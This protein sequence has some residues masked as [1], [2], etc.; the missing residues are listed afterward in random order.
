MAVLALQ[1]GAREV[2]LVSWEQVEG[3]V[4]LPGV[5]GASRQSRAMF[6]QNGRGRRISMREQRWTD[7][8][9]GFGV[10]WER[11]EEA[12]LEWCD[13]ILDKARCSEGYD[14]GF[15]GVR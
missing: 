2:A 12:G 10:G 5:V 1:E 13:E 4:H 8:N 9:L 6:R 14:E 11:K 3:A 7:L 15:P